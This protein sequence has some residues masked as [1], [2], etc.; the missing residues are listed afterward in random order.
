MTKKKLCD[1][2]SLLISIV[3]NQKSLEIQ[4]TVLGRIQVKSLTSL[5]T[6][7]EASLMTTSNRVID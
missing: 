2:I 4:A 3:L 6:A 7:I 1:L 5:V